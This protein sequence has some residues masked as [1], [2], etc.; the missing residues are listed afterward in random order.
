MNR[1]AQSIPQSN[2]TTFGREQ[3]R[4]LPA[5][6]VI[7]YEYVADFTLK[8]DVGNVVQ[9]VINVS[10]EGVFVAVAIGYGLVEERVEAIDLPVGPEKLKDVTLEDLPPDVLIE[11]FRLNPNLRSLLL[12][13]GGLNAELPIPPELRRQL[14]QRFKPVDNFS[15]LLSLVDTGTGRE[16]Q[17][18]PVHSVATLGGPMGAGRSRCCRN[19]WS[20]CR[21]RRFACKSKNAPPA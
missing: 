16:L 1:M 7:P 11:G 17:N 6:R 14:I 18:K 19:R 13:D 15:F 3:L 20:F 10:V 4:G 2:V 8:G 5:G 21:A 9:D 12:L